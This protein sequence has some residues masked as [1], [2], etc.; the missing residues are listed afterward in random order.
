MARHTGYFTYLEQCGT[1]CRVVLGDARLSLAHAPERAYGLIVLDAFSSDAIPM[2]LVTSEAVS[3]YLTHLAPG[4]VIA[5]HISNRHVLLSPVL[6]RLA[7][8]HGLTA[9]ERRDLFSDDW[10]KDKTESHW[11]LMA[12]NRTDLEPLVG[13]D[14]WTLLAATTSSPLWRDDFSN[15]VG[16]LSFR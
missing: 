9:I 10:P 12:R 6:A 5:F 16:V 7:Q 15:I 11:V 4:G 2:H 3:L 8:N 1:R 13:R 14:R